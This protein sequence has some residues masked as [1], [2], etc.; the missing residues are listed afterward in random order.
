MIA[1]HPESCIRIH[2]SYDTHS[3][4]VGVGGVVIRSLPRRHSPYGLKSHG[5]VPVCNDDYSARWIH[6]AT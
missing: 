4:G 1:L 3:G 5:E 6:A 2:V